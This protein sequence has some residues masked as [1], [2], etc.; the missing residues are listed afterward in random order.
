MHNLATVCQQAK[1][2]LEQVDESLRQAAPLADLDRLVAQSRLQARY[3]GYHA[4]PQ[5]RASLIRVGETFGQPVQ[6][7]V[8]Q[9]LLARLVLDF[10]EDQLSF[11]VTEG[12]RG[13]YVSSLCRIIGTPVDQWRLDDAFF[14]D[15]ALVGGRMFPAGERVVEPYSVIQ[16]SLAYRRG[17]RQAY[18]FAHTL[19]RLRGSRPVFRLHIHLSE[20]PRLSV[21]SWRQTCIHL[22]EML[23]LNPVVKGIVGSS[24][25][26][27]PELPLVTPR[28]AFINSLLRAGGARWFLS[29]LED[30]HSGAFARSQHRRTAFAEGRYIPRCFTIVWPRKEALAWLERGEA[31]S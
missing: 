26:Y 24:W 21:V 30:G 18:D 1:R 28:L 16:R 19:L 4:L 20:A 17:F 29:H 6:S 14:K 22:V 9:G 3:G 11:E 15:L 8:M 10:R 31:A 27:D 13:M 7:R 5:L 23:R 2:T 25:F 12:V